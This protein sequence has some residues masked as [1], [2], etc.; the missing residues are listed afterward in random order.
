M[1]N[2]CYHNNIMTILFSYNMKIIKVNR[3]LFS[4][5]W[6]LLNVSSEI[7]I[8]VYYTIYLYPVC[9]IATLY[10]FIFLY[11]SFAHLRRA[12]T[13]IS[14]PRKKSHFPARQDEQALVLHHRSSYPKN[15]LPQVRVYF[16]TI[17][18]EDTIKSSNRPIKS[19]NPL[20]LFS[21]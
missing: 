18:Y 12:R 9:Y 7:R 1:S 6:E 21:R 19:C 15:V 16:R 14:S 13:F 17:W 20:H 5:L 4:L 8:P 11:V 2:I 3:I 10:P